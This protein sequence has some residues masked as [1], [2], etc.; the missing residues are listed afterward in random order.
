MRLYIPTKKSLLFLLVIAL[1]LFLV[2]STVQIALAAV[3]LVGFTATPGN[4]QVLVAWETANEV[5]NAGF[6]VYRSTNQNSGFEV[7]SLLIPAISG[8]PTSG[9]YSYTDRGV[10]NNVGYYYELVAI[11]NSNESQTFPPIGPIM[12]GVTTATA[13][14]TSVVTRTPTATGSTNAQTSTPT[15]NPTQVRTPTATQNVAYPSPVQ[16]PYPGPVQSATPTRQQTSSPNPATSTS[17]SGA[18][19]DGVTT[20][21]NGLE[22]T[23][24]P[25][26]TLRPFPSITIEF[27]DATLTPV[28][29]KQSTPGPGDS[30][31][32]T[33]W[34]N[35]A[36]IGPLALIVLV[37]VLL[38][39]WFYLTLRRME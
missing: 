24:G 5:D 32:L 27:P 1:L 17:S 22:M 12:P 37:W 38:G 14:G 7:I 34:V 19:T 16:S 9:E 10:T 20:T 36:R 11:S 30:N 3:T 28:V 23:G 2:A 35:V 33:G 15:R 8:Y 39:G 29:F 31:G 18:R 25:T 4:G 6:F 13:T 26:S 21:T